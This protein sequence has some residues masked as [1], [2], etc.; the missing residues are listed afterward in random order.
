MCAGLGAC[1]TLKPESSVRL[2]PPATA[3]MTSLD[4]IPDAMICERS[5]GA[6]ETCP[7]LGGLNASDKSELASFVEQNRAAEPQLEAPPPATLMQA[8]DEAE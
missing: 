6:D 3:E 1:A 7:V 2:A 5:F 4:E 8:T